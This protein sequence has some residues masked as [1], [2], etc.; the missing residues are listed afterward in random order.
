MQ[1]N[2]KLLICHYQ[3]RGDFSEL[4]A[5][6]QTLSIPTQAFNGHTKHVQDDLSGP[7][8][9][10][11]ICNAWKPSGCRSLQWEET[12]NSKGCQCIAGEPGSAC[13]ENAHCEADNNCVCNEGYTGD[14]LV[15]CEADYFCFH[16]A[17]KTWSEHEVDAAVLH[18]HLASIRSPEEN[19]IV[20]QLVEAAWE[21]SGA[22]YADGFLHV[23]LGGRKNPEDGS[24]SWLDGSGTFWTNGDCDAGG[25]PVA[26]VYENFYCNESTL[27]NQQPDSD[28][29]CLDM[30][31]LLSTD[32]PYSGYWNDYDCNTPFFGVYRIPSDFFFPSLLTDYMCVPAIA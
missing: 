7:C 8:V 11:D 24:W 2:D 32:I 31:H 18:G 9:C 10:E 6:F 22:G 19:D 26:E 3:E 25:Q 13:A 5:Y 14:P 17:E 12:V 29:T 27:G 23:F 28:G 30:F 1:K 21:E 16:F 20:Y 15:S 4:T